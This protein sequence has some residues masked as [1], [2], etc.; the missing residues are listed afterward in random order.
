MCDIEVG[1]RDSSRFF[2]FITG[3]SVRSRCPTVWLWCQTVHCITQTESLRSSFSFRMLHFYLYQEFWSYRVEVKVDGL[4]GNS[5]TQHRSRA[6]HFEFDSWYIRNVNEMLNKDSTCNL[7]PDLGLPK[8]LRLDFC[9]YFFLFLKMFFKP[10]F[11]SSIMTVALIIKCRGVIYIR[12]R[13][14]NSYIQCI[15]HFYKLST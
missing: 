8:D 7:G 10:S 9:H 12:R 11:S 5:S 14:I 1:I 15:N 2:S 3:S 13:V 6:A 4:G